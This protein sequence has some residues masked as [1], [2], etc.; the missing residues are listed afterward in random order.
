[1]SLQTQLVAAL[2]QIGKDMNALAL[3]DGNLATLDTTTKASL[4]A[5]IN[6]VLQIAKNASSGSGGAKI[7]DQAT[8]TDTTATYSAAKISDLVKTAADSLRTQLV[9]KA[10]AALDTLE[11]LATALGN[12]ANFATTI[13]NG[14]NNRIRFD[15]PQ[16]LTIA[17]QKQAGENMGI[18]D[19]N[20]DYLG[21]YTTA[22]GTI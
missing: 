14:L 13:T 16:T 15:E 4:V 19:P 20:F 8:N 11:E 12:D 7:N 9:G 3:R 1:M 21:T 10:S 18:G 22:R 2:Q 6:E 5:A 17:Q